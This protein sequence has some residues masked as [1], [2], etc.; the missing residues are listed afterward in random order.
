MGRCDCDCDCDFDFVGEYTG[1]YTKTIVE[2]GITKSS[3][4]I[5]TLKISQAGVGAYLQTETDESGTFTTL[6]FE[7]NGVLIAEAQTGNGIINTYYSGKCLIHQ[8]SIKTPTTWIVKN[9]KFKRNKH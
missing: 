3:E 1:R 9:F 8:I 2:G 4:G 6:A 5:G 7:N